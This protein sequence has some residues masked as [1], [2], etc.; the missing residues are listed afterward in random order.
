MNALIEKG[1]LFPKS[2][3]EGEA[4]RRQDQRR[5]R[6]DRASRT[7]LASFEKADIMTRATI[8][9]NRLIRRVERVVIAPLLFAK[10]GSAPG[11]GM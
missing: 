8:V 6:P 4:C 11:L 10:V 1:L 5:L 9:L 7:V 3:S 2:R